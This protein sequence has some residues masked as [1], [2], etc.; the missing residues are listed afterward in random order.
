MSP[1]CISPSSSSP[2]VKL[3][4]VFQGASAAFEPGYCLMFC[5]HSFI[6]VDG[7]W[8][9]AWRTGSFE[10]RFFFWTLIWSCVSPFL[11]LAA[12]FFF[13]F[14]GPYSILEEFW[15]SLNRAFLLC[16]QTLLMSND[17][18]KCAT[19]LH[20][21]ALHIL[22]SAFVL[23]L[24]SVYCVRMKLEVRMQAACDAS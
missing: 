12:A 23:C 1:F 13:L 7:M 17:F 18:C 5:P 3:L 14:F 2:A 9:C 6:S 4:Q 10:L 22:L 11:T 15:D 8:L 20:R 24:V 16:G 21:H 19:H